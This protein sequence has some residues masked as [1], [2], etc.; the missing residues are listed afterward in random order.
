MP[1]FSMEE[2]SAINSAVLIYQESVHIGAI[3]EQVGFGCDH[4][5]H[6]VAARD[7]ITK[8]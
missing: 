2:R 8:C 4:T 5:W 6:W 3:Q 1:R 7:D